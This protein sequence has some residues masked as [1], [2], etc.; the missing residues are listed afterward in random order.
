[1]PKSDLLKQAIADANAVRETAIANARIALQEQF[2]TRIQGMLASKLAEQLDDEELPADDEMSDEMPMDSEMEDDMGMD[3]EMGDDMG[4]E[5]E[6]GQTLGDEPITFS[7]PDGGNLT[8]DYD[9]AGGGD[10]ESEMGDDV[11]MEAEYDEEDLELESILR[12]LDSATPTGPEDEL[13]EY[14]DEMENDSELTESQLNEI[15]DSILSEEM[16]TEPE[17]EDEAI[18]DAA[19]EELEEAYKT[20]QH[21]RSVINEVNLLNAK[22][23]YTNKLFRNFELSESQKMK[24]IEN[25]DRATNSREVKLVFA[26]LAESFKRPVHKRAIK[27]NVTKQRKPVASASKAVAS[28]KPKQNVIT[29]GNDYVKRFQKLAGILR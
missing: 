19:A 6:M 13:Y 9:S 14:E 20:I 25:F 21:L 5:D 26:T 1:M 22:L 28:T 17:M 24:V 7:L 18:E 29:E 10:M 8:I 3:S 15:I 23:L 11:D 12:E 27:E 2:N 4:M 16:E